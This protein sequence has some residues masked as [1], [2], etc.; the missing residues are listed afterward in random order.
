MSDSPHDGARWLLEHHRDL[1]DAEFAINEGGGGTLRD[2]KPVRNSIQLAEKIYQ[3]YRLEVTDP[4]GHSAS[5]RRD[6]AIYRLADGL[7]RLSQFDFPAHLNAVTRGYFEQ[8]RQRPS[9]GEVADA[10]TAAARRQRT[11]ERRSCR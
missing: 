1:I 2:G 6:N 10:I 9:S 7:A 3:S 4:G 8:R 11:T 5:G